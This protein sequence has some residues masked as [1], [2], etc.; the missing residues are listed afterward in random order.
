MDEAHVEHAVGFVEHE[1]LDAVE[2]DGA[3][4]H[5]VEQPAGRRHQ[6]VDAAGERADLAAERNPAD[7][8]R[9]ART[10]I[11]AVGLEAFDDLGGELAG[12]AQHQ[13]AAGASAPRRRR[14]L[15]R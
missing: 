12:R 14:F 13:H 3:L 5:E 11:A 7:G 9:D 8:E 1:D 6:D 4:L 10:Q 15:E 2:V